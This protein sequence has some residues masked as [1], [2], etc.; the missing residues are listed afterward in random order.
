MFG[1]SKLFLVQALLQ[2]VDSLYQQQWTFLLRRKI[3][4]RG[5]VL[6]AHALADTGVSSESPASKCSPFFGNVGWHGQR[7]RAH[8]TLVC[9]SGS[10]K[11]TQKHEVLERFFKIDHIA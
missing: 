2:G 10:L 8:A 1:N 7:P 11:N 4:P 3:K 6:K 9:M 5:I